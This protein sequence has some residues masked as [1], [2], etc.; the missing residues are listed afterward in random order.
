VRERAGLQVTNL[1]AP[2]DVL[3]MRL[4]RRP[5]DPEQT[6]GFVNYGHLFVT[7]NRGDYWQCA[8]VIRKGGY[9]AVRERGLDAFRAEIVKLAPYLADRVQEL[10]DWDD[11]RLLTVAVDRLT[12]WWRPGLLC[13][14]DAAH[15][16]S[17]IG[18]V[19][20]NLAVQD[21]VAAANI[22]AAPLRE[23]KL[24][25]GDLEAVQRRRTFP[26]K[27]VQAM[28]LGVQSRIVDPLLD[29]DKPVTAPWIVRLFNRF[30]FLRRIPARIVGIG[31]RPEHV[32]S[33]QLDSPAG[34]LAQS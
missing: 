2:M 27:V 30:P 21:A 5:G 31:V 15:A 24:T 28:Q 3:W 20:V 12:Q 25:T 19:G 32:R 8:F 1:G 33:P 6:G 10:K 34:A 22:L 18:G 9:D 17:P 16:M 13:I 11:I 7:L 23:R 29:S 26:M 14:G 4:S